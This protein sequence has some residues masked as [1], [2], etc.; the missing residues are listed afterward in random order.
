MNLRIGL[1]CG[2]SHP[3]MVSSFFSPFIFHFSS[4]KIQ[5]KIY[6]TNRDAVNHHNSRHSCTHT[7][8][9]TIHICSLNSLNETFSF[10]PGNFAH[11]FETFTINQSHHILS[12][13][14][15]FSVCMNNEMSWCANQ[16]T[17]SVCV[18]IL[19]FQLFSF[20]FRSTSAGCAVEN[21]VSPTNVLWPRKINVR[22][23]LDK[24]GHVDYNTRFMNYYVFR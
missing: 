6:V 4:W 7:H 13:T 1:R 2:F 16:R 14:F 22:S 18:K 3:L 20:I 8:T 12:V 19:W 21:V 17:V 23:S 5:I 10:R 24:I 9:H 15:C 11:L